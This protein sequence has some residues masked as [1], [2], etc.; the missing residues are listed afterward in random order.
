MP[1]QQVGAKGRRYGARLR[2]FRE[3]VMTNRIK[4]SYAD[5]GMDT[6]RGDN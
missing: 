1:P 5:C 2:H 3:V 6:L 4:A